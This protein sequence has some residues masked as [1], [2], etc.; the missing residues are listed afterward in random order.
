MSRSFRITT[1]IVFGLLALGSALM[2]PRLKF[3]FDFEQFFPKGDK[4]LAFFREFIQDFETDDNFLLL[5]LVREEGVFDSAFLSKVH[6]LSLEARKLP[7]VEESF[8]LTQFAYPLKT[9]FGLTSIPAIHLDDP[10]RYE[11]DRK[12]VLADERLVYNLIDPEGKALVV[13][14]KTIPNISL[15]QS[16]ELMAAIQELVQP[17]GFENH[18]LLGRSYFQKE[19]VAMQKREI[20]VSA[21]FAGLLVSLVMGAIFRRFWGIV[22]S[23]A[24]VALGMLLFMGFLAVTG[25]ELSAM[26]ALYPVLMLIV[27][28]S[29]VIHIMSKY[30]DE[31]QRGNPRF[32]AI[33]TT[34][35]EVGLAT[36]L[37]SATT[38]VGF[39]SL[40]T[41]RIQPIR[42][43][44]L[45]SAIGVLIA[46]GT[47]LFFTTSMLSL[48]H[49]D[50]IVKIGVTD[51]FWNRHMTR[52]FQFTRSRSRAIGWGGAALAVLCL[53]GIAQITTNY[54][55]IHNLP[56]GAR[57]TED[58]R[59]FEERFTGFRPMEVA[60]TAKAPYK[61]DD[62][63]VLREMS[64]LEEHLSQYEPIRAAT[65]MT[66]AY[67][68]MNQLFHGNR[69]EEYRFPETEAE[70]RRYERYVKDMPKLGANVLVSKDGEKARITARLLD[71]GADSIKAMNAS[72]D[73][74]VAQNLD[75]AKL[76]VRITGT[77]LIVDK[78]SEYVR[79]S[80]L[81][82]LGLAVLVVALLMGLLFRDLRMVLVAIVPNLIPLLVA[83]ALL[84][85]L[86][87]ELEA[88]VSIVFSVIFGIAV[89]DTIHFLSKY[90]LSLA[91]GLSQEEAIRITFLETGK[92]IVLTS[93]LLFAGFMIMLFS[94]HPPSVIIGL[95]ISATLVSAVVC[96]L[97]LIP[98]LIRWITPER[99][100]DR[101]PAEMTS[102]LKRD[103][104]SAPLRKR[105]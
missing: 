68:T 16:E 1:F 6:D 77:G 24:S 31:L 25:R 37:T 86:G 33:K 83:G 58:F 93:I 99:N 98:P 4:D 67:K 23:L 96:D 19:L 55:L 91:K 5:A 62:F 45:N 76:D 10:G 69:K 14:L 79:R 74:W 80:L 28:T 21:L 27:G 95:L 57:I 87:I 61:A 49:A 8:S 51:N 104:I 34:V 3:S 7:H 92:A 94:I 40:L 105:L 101:T 43:F 26:A 22:V 102:L 20:L 70:F 29:D 11:S 64:L 72:I 13:Y 66:T 75:Q 60:I 35:K 18:H 90:R 56:R 65:S 63:E 88:G 39:L 53:I 85:Y 100:G 32:Q 2:L 30:L 59:F 47:V 38:A 81:L 89:D 36:L 9:P 78:N 50:Q 42:D 97:L 84:G 82:G 103:V 52:L 48:F 73:Q 17:Y 54:T 12:K 15:D 41:S 46:F 44:G 71:V